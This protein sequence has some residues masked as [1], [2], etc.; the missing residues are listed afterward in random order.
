MFN[1]YYETINQTYNSHIN[2]TENHFCALSQTLHIYSSSYNNFIILSHFNIQMKEEQIK[3]FC[4][5]YGFKSLIR[6]PTCYKIPSNLTFTELIL[7]NAPKKYPSTDV[8]ET[9]L[10]DFYLITVKVM[11]KIFKKLKSRTINYRSYK[12]YSNKVYRRSLL[13]ELSKE[14][15]VINDHDL[16]KFCDININI[17]NRHAAGNRKHAQGNQMPFITKDLSKP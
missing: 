7:T 3:A 14:V 9:R 12:H 6:Q 4:D 10:S 8:L 11:G 5:N 1:K 2:N 16:Q 13:H 17:L 15:F